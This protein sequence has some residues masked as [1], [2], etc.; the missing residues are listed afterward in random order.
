MLAKAQLRHP[1]SEPSVDW[2]LAR[3]RCFREARR[4]LDREDAEEAVQEAMTRAWRGWRSCR[5]PEEPTAWMLQI[6]RREAIRQLD[7]RR[8]IAE[9][10]RHELTEIPSLDPPVDQVVTAIDAEQ[11]LA[12]L[13][14]DER[15]L[16]ELRYV[17][18]LT[19]PQVAQ[20]L[21]IPE[22]TVKVRLHR[23]RRRLQSAFADQSGC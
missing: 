18:D 4:M 12:T 16:I 3:Q 15:R 22:G 21:D 9:R 10:E 2:A 11:A 1:N 7:R 19:Q 17:D 6:T 8:R 14:P 23:L 20:M 5:N 13:R